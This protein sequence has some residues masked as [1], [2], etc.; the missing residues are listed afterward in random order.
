MKALSFIFSLSVLS[1]AAACDKSGGGVTGTY[2]DR[3]IRFGS[4][5]CT[6]A[7]AETTV[8]VIKSDGFD[9]TAI[10]DDRSVLFEETARWDESEQAFIPGRGYRFPEEGKLSFYAVCPTGEKLSVTGESVSFPF[11]HNPD[12]DVVTAFVESADVRGGKVMLN[13]RHILSL[14]RFKLVC[15]DAGQTLRVRK[16]SIRTPASGEFDLRAGVW[17]TG[18]DV[19][20]ECL[21]EPLEFMTSSDVR[22]SF[23]FLPCAPVIHVE[24][25]MFHADTTSVYESREADVSLDFI[26][27][28]G[29]GYVVT[30]KFPGQPSETVDFAVSL[31]PW[32]YIDK[33]I[34][35]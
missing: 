33:P 28:T 5:I 6:R 34:D 25:D 26:A 2:D 7:F 1:V 32:E 35:I 23:S 3:A 31:Q 20:T 29:R 18:G 17:K 16:L 21:T 4:E 10:C 14:I 8:G 11:V 19:S 15:N 12:K 22:G 24:W 30:I 13:F 9:V 27:E